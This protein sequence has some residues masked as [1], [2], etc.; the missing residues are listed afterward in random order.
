MNTSTMRNLSSYPEPLGD[1]FKSNSGA[2]AGPIGWKGGLTN[3]NAVQDEFFAPKSGF[4][5]Y[6]TPSQRRILLLLVEWWSGQFDTNNAIESIK[7]AIREHANSSFSDQIEIRELNIESKG[8]YHTKLLQALTSEFFIH[9]TAKSQLAQVRR[10]TASLV[11]ACQRIA[12]LV[13]LPNKELIAKLEPPA[14]ENSNLAFITTERQVSGGVPGSSGLSGEQTYTTNDPLPSAILEVCPWLSAEKKAGLPY[15]L[16]DIEAKETVVVKEL[17][18]SPAYTIISHTWGRWRVPESDPDASVKVRGVPWL[19]PR[20]SKFDVERMPDI[21][22]LHA[23]AFAP[24]K[25]IWFDLFCIPQDRSPLA[26][27]EISRQ[28]AIF[29]TA[30]RAACW[31]NTITD[32]KG[33]RAAVQWLSIVFLRRA[34]ASDRITEALAS[35]NHMDIHPTQLFK[36]FIER[37]PESPNFAVGQ[38]PCGW[39]TSLWTL[40]EFCLRPD[41][42]LFDRNWDLFRLLDGTASAPMPL[43]N[44]LA[45]V[46]DFT[47]HGWDAPIEQ[48]RVVVELLALTDSTCI[49]DILDSSP[50][51]ILVL[52]DRRECNHQRAEAIMSVVGATDW[53]LRTPKELHEENLVLGKFPI[54]FLREVREREGARFFASTYGKICCFWDIFQSEHE[55]VEHFETTHS[56]L[57]ADED[58]EETEEE[59]QDVDEDMEDAE[60]EIELTTKVAGTILPF[61]PIRTQSKIIGRG[62]GVKDHPTTATWQL[63]NDGRV[64]M[65]NVAILASTDPSLDKDTDYN[66]AALVFA[67][68]DENPQ[69]MGEPKTVNLHKYLTAPF[70][71][72]D[73]VPK[74]AIPILYRD[75]GWA[76]GII[77]MEVFNN[78]QPVKTFA[79]LGDFFTMPRDTIA[80]PREW[81]VNWEIL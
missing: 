45:L 42:L 12:H 46:E 52:A 25:Y 76:Q 18:G 8:P 27:L 41:M 66:L 31:L 61:D 73:L 70:P 68:S 35:I 63:A 20:N 37:L 10:Q 80:E 40:Q 32:W 22:C 16:W 17:T 77:L 64:L 65:P 5:E 21:F 29:G 28:A 44:I 11:S 23:K 7:I 14:S 33:L 56:T 62:P 4:M 3:W 6:L 58:V 78:E 38:E 15:Y 26:L 59:A 48:P 55:E 75:D 60:E 72:Q 39:F 49:L 71:G 67:P 34:M 54:Q 50:L 74:H 2:I 57:E 36:E 69:R 53:Y 24:T 30:S 13:L 43:D 51:A 79:K 1:A 19:V 9:P 81:E 47:K